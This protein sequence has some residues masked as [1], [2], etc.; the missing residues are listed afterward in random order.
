MSDFGSVEERF[1][2][3]IEKTAGCWLW[4]G[5]CSGNGYGSFWA[6]KNVPAHRFAYE[7]FRGPIP[8]RMWVCHTC[9]TPLCVNPEHFFLGTSSDNLLDASRKGRLNIV[10]TVKTHCQRGHEYSGANLYITPKGWRDCRVCRREASRRWEQKE[11]QRY[12]R[13]RSV[14]CG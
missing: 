9:D 2:S 4:R 11:K 13:P 5:G 6:G 12:S 14:T 10:N 1:L 7:M 3:K 8:S